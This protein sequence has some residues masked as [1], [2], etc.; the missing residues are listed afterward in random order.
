MSSI[1]C[2]ST[3]KS[4]AS[5]DGSNWNFLGS[6]STTNGVGNSNYYISSLVMNGTNNLFV[7][8]S[9]TFIPT[10]P[11]TNVNG[12]A[13]WDG[14]NWNILGINSTNNGVIGN[15]PVPYALAMNG[16]HNLFVGGRFTN[17]DGDSIGVNSIAMWDGNHWNGVG[18][19][20]GQV[21]CFV[22]N[23]SNLFVGGSFSLSGYEKIAS[24][25]I[26]EI[27]TTSTQQNPTSSNWTILGGGIAGSNPTIGALAMNGSHNL[28]VGGA[29]SNINGHSISANNIA[30]WDGNAW[31][32]LG[33]N[34]TNNGVNGGEVI[35]LAMN[36]TNNLFVAGSFTSVGGNTISSNNIASWDGSNWNILGTNST[37]NGVGSAGNDIVFS[38]A[39]NGTNN[40]FVG[41]FFSSV[42]GNSI[43]VN[44][45]A[46][47]DGSNWN[48][49]GLNSTNNGVGS[50]GF[51]SFNS[52]NALVMNGT[53]NLFVGGSFSNLNGGLVSANNVASWDGSNWNI[54]GTN[55]TYNGVVTART[56]LVNS[57]AMN[58]TH[59]LFVG[60]RFSSVD[61]GLVS[62]KNIASWDGSNWN[63]LGT[64]ST[65]N[66]VGIGSSEI[67][68]SLFM[69]ETNILL[70]GGQ[71][72]TVDGSIPAINAAFWNGST[73]NSVG[74]GGTDINAYIN[75]FAINSTN[76]D[77]FVGGQFIFS[78]DGLC[79]P[80][81][82]KGRLRICYFCLNKIF[83]LKTKQKRFPLQSIC[84]NDDSG[85]PNNFNLN[86]TDNNSN[87]NKSKWINN[88]VSITISCQRSLKYKII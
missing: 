30:S 35:C 77:L 10:L 20:N 66:G 42:D 2:K 28:F 15:S 73:W 18:D 81:L 21:F 53:N 84:S 70:A 22:T 63:F 60:G 5:W 8:G 47:W 40:L 62:T 23:G 69:I 38:L 4:I 79:A 75:N 76:S 1:H 74:S 34:S 87:F 13:S 6:N 57:L 43:S 37:N 49:L 88:Y 14:S 9:F 25:N 12:I 33:T 71:F 11:S 51:L 83:L 3:N 16:T 46:S 82:I 17:I 26:A 64:S 24:S 19:T 78:P 72:T 52:V 59:T 54:L 27:T 41:G 39:M 67:I 50:G 44:N 32:V 7:G 45:I 58:G 55:S 56:D 80:Y 68:R 29:F 65:N 31:H 86:T 48:I 36:G 61:G 85:N